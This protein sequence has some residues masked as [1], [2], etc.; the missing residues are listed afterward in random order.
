[1]TN[2]TISGSSSLTFHIYVA[3]FHHRLHMVCMSL[4]LFDTQDQYDQFLNRGRLLTD[5][6]LL[7]GLQRS[8][9]EA[10]FCKFY[11]RYNNL[12]YQY[13]LPLSQMLSGV[14]H[15]HCS[16]VFHTLIW[17]RIVPFACS[18]LWAHGGCDRS[19]GDASPRHLIPPFVFPGVRVCQT[20][21][22]AFY[23]GLTI[24]ITVRYSW[25]YAHYS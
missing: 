8:R 23:L 9:L 2:W 10:A 14:F 1:M 20:L 12:V 3:I 5:K 13:D 21:V 7:Q 15:S 4:N 16:A 17:L 25:P 19:T 24:L 22:F 18:R 11:G 6:L